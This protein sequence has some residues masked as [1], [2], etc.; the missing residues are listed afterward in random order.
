MIIKKDKYPYP[1]IS[2]VEKNGVRHYDVD[3]DLLPS[4]TTILSF[5]KDTT[6]LDRWRERIGDKE[7]DRIV[8]ESS[9]IGNTIHDN[10]ENFVLKGDKPIGTVLEKMMTNVIIKKGLCNLQEVWGCEVA[11]YCRGLYAGT[12]DVTGVYNNSPSIVDYKNSRKEKKEEWIEDYYK[13]LC[14]YGCA[15]NE[16]FGTNI[17]KGDILMITRDCKFLHYELSG[18][19]YQ[20]YLTKWLKDLENYI[21]H[22]DK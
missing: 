18:K 2:R 7:A 5:N 12:T 13:Q 4:V 14:A 1:N 3:G 11:L 10:L 8:K 9:D 20:K 19:K 6:F 22:A 16:M 17:K 21:N 15:H